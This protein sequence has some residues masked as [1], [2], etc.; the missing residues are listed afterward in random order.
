MPGQFVRIYRRFTGSRRNSGTGGAG[1]F[2]WT[3]RFSAAARTGLLWVAAVRRDGDGKRGPANGA[4]GEPLAR[5]SG[6][7][8]ISEPQAEES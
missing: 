3:A 5:P 1:F 4:E 8:R 2:E 7:G 6:F